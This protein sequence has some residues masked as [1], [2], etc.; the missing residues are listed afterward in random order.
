MSPAD[1][2]VVDA[3]HEASLISLSLYLETLTT[4]HQCLDTGHEFPYSEDPNVAL[5]FG[6]TLLQ[7]LDSLA[8]PVIPP[9]LHAK[10]LQATSRDE[11]FE[12]RSSM[13]RYLLKLV[14]KL[15]VFF[16]FWTCS[17]RRQ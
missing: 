4:T 16:S 9:M 8:E 17:L 13:I 14:F 12:V 15:F 6:E 7:L 5:A 10:C 3:I 2:D 1:T 11:A